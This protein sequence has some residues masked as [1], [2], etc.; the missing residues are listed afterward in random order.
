MTKYTAQ[1]DKAQALIAKFGLSCVLERAADGTVSTYDQSDFGTLTPSGNTFTFSTGDVSAAISVGD[2]VTFREV[3]AFGNRGP[4]AVTAVSSGSI[5]VDGSLTDSEDTEWFMDVES[6]EAAYASDVGVP[7]PPQSVTGQQFAQDFRDGT[8][9]IS[10]AQDLILSAKDL[11]FSPKPGDKIQF[12]Q[13]TWSSS[14]DVWT[15]HGIGALAPDG[16]PI[17]WQGIVTRG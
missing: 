7:L 17:I 1:I 4:F 11:E 16:T 13:A 8:L 15:I 10:R 6:S 12:G 3:S 9:Q 5:T 14:A 2:T